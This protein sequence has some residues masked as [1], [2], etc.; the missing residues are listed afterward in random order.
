MKS[1][2]SVKRGVKL[3][4]LD[5]PMGGKVYPLAHLWEAYFPLDADGMTVTSGHE[6]APGDGVHRKDSLHYKGRAIDLRVRDVRVEDVK[7]RFVPAAR[8]LLGPD[9]D[10]I[11]EGDHVHIEYDPAPDGGSR[12]VVAETATGTITHGGGRPA[13]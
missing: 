2:L 3:N 5:P 4:H 10:V 13:A 7:A 11:F 12:E 6:G 9:F 1:L 8:L